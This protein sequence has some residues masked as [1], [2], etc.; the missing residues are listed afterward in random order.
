MTKL[1]L[2]AW[3]LP[4]KNPVLKFVADH[5]Y[6]TTEDKKLVWGCWG[7]HTGGQKVAQGEANKE[8]TVCIA[9]S[10]GSSGEGTAGVLVYAVNGVCHQTANRILRDTRQTVYK[11]KGY[12]ASWALYGPYGTISP[13]G[14]KDPLWIIRETKCG[15]KWWSKDPLWLNNSTTS[16]IYYEELSNFYSDLND[17]LQQNKLGSAKEVEILLYT[18]ELKALAKS[19]LSEELSLEK[20]NSIVKYQIQMKDELSVFSLKNINN[21]TLGR[22]NADN[23]NK[24]LNIFLQ[25]VATTITESEYEAIFD[26]KPGIEISVVNPEF[27]LNDDIK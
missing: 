18:G 12:A 4:V 23:I 5:T 6:V 20:I 15:I 16:D 11:A 21:N 25:K 22:E 17:N 1:K 10:D 19:R 27:T 9:G 13:G 3:A 24:I 14:M 8:I 2:E 26:C 7:G